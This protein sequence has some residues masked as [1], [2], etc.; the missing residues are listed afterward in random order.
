[1]PIVRTYSAV[2]KGVTLKIPAASS[3]ATI[4]RD[5]IEIQ[6]LSTTSDLVASIEFELIIFEGGARSAV[7]NSNSIR[8]RDAVVLSGSIQ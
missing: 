5:I 4:R 8:L 2:F 6:L 7:I 3:A 1:M